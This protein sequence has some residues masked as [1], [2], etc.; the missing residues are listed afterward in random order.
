MKRLLIFALLLSFSK[1][2]LSQQIKTDSLL[3]EKLNAEWIL[4]FKSINSKKL[5][6]EFIKEKIYY[7]SKFNARIGTC[8]VEIDRNHEDYRGE[9]YY[10]E[11]KVLFLLKLDKKHYILGV[12]ILDQIK[13]NNLNDITIIKSDINLPGICGNITIEINDKKLKRKIKNVL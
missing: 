3:T 2:I 13:Q 8:F 1:T 7:D 4:K 5:K 6:L 9:D 10:Y 12:N 11:C